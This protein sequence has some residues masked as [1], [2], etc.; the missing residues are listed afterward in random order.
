MVTSQEYDSHV[1]YIRKMP[2]ESVL[3]SDS[4]QRASLTEDITYHSGCFEL[5]DRDTSKILL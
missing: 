2:T 3:C 1:K 5:Y 4:S